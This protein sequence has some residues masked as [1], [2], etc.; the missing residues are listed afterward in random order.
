M[1][2]FKQVVLLVFFSILTISSEALAQTLKVGIPIKYSEPFIIQRED[3]VNGTIVEGMIIDIWEDIALKKKLDYEF[4][5][6]DNYNDAID[7]VARGELDILVG[8]VSITPDRMEKVEFTLPVDEYEIVV[9]SHSDATSLWSRIKPFVGIASLSS[10]GVLIISIF[11]VGNLVWLVEHKKNPESFPE[12]YIHGV[13]NGMWFAM[14]TLTT[15]GYGDY[16]P[17]TKIGRLIAT[18]WMLI[19]LL[20]LSSITAGLASAFTVALSDQNPAFSDVNDLRRAKIA[21]VTGW[22]SARWAGYYGAEVV[23]AATLEEAI[24]LVSEQKVDGLI[25]NRS[26]L[27]YY[28]QQNPDFNLSIAN[29]TI[30]NDLYGFALPKESPLTHELDAAIVQM[31][32]STEIEI[33]KDKWF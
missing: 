27:V 6:H 14:V 13:G 28:I 31:R 30:A 25:S 5:Y 11:I 17:V 18:L 12:N 19:T 32:S 1:F 3:S 22:S 4:I 20:A 26:T 23:E 10:I 8:P 9:A 29:F 2:K 7:A 21:V 15:V 24:R 16:A 33:S